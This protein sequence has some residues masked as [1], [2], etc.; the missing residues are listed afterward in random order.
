MKDFIK[1]YC[2]HVGKQNGYTIVNFD[3]Y[4]Y[5]KMVEDF[6]SINNYGM[7]AEPIGYE[8]EEPMYGEDFFH[9]LDT[10]DIDDI[11]GYR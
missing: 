6:R 8:Y 10:R 2:K 11:P 3:D 5:G 1:E 7:V 9:D 4:P